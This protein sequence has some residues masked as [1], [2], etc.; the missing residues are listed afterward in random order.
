M[1]ASDHLNKSQFKIYY[2]GLQPDI[3]LKDTPVTHHHLVAKKEK[4]QVG[5]MQVMHGGEIAHVEVD[6]AHQRQGIATALW[7]HA[8]KLGLNP[9]HSEVMSDEGEAWAKSLGYKK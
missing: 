6:A 7:K 5:L 2:Q 8:E 3:T 4:K 1:S 9:S